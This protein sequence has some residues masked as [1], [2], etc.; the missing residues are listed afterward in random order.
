MSKVERTLGQN[1]EAALTLTHPNGSTCEIYVPGGHLVSWRTPNGANG[2]LEEQLFVSSATKYLPSKPIRGGV[3]VCFPQFGSYGPGGKHG[4]ARNSEN[5]TVGATY[6]DSATLELVGDGTE[7]PKWPHKFKLSLTV[8]LGPFSLQMA[9]GVENTGRSEMSFTCLL[10]T[11]FRVS[12]ITKAYVTGFQDETYVTD[13]E[14]EKG[15]FTDNRE[16]AIVEAETD[17]IYF[18]CPDRLVISEEGGRRGGSLTINKDGFS[19][20]VLWNIW[21]QGGDSMGDL[22]KGEWRNFICV[23]AGQIGDAVVLPAGESW[24]AEQ[25]FEVILYTAATTSA[26]TSTA[27]AAATTTLTYMCACTHTYS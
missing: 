5:W 1:G 19:D 22:G 21:E 8:T 11:Y 17:R 9:M 14:A 12:D 23:E 26:S 15:T 16:K 7:D 10:H 2:E 6:P 20:V 3:P 18:N 25:D 13:N 27:T 24:R 4:F